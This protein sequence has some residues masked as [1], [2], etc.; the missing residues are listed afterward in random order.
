MLRVGCQEAEKCALQMLEVRVREEDSCRGRGKGAREMSENEPLDKSER[1]AQYGLALALPSDMLTILIRV[2][3]RS[4]HGRM[5][6]LRPVEA[7]CNHNALTPEEVLAPA[8]V[9][10]PFAVDQVLP[11][12]VVFDVDKGREGCGAFDISKLQSQKNELATARRRRRV[13][14]CSAGSATTT[15]THTRPLCVGPLLRARL[16]NLLHEILSGLTSV[17]AYMR[18]PTEESLGHLAAPR[19]GLVQCKHISAKLAVVAHACFGPC[20]K[21]EVGW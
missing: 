8:R 3:L 5:K 9:A 1:L 16:L 20:G 2:F 6:V 10:H 13:S 7:V 18:V 15:T 21:A 14:A 12:A 17:F 19:P 4:D 11:F